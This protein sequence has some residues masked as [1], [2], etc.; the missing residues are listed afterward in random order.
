MAWTG[1]SPY[2]PCSSYELPKQHKKEVNKI[3][4]RINELV[5]VRLRINCV[6][7]MTRFEK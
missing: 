6:V 1:R 4:F 5:K 2:M 7:I 3:S